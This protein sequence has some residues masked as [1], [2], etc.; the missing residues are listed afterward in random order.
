MQDYLEK[1]VAAIGAVT[2]KV[3]SLSDLELAFILGVF[4][5]GSLWSIASYVA[6]LLEERKRKRLFLHE[7]SLYGNQGSNVTGGREGQ[8]ENDALRQ[9]H[10]SHDSPEKRNPFD[11]HSEHPAGPSNPDHEEDHQDDQSVP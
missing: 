10:S 4:L 8:T 1:A 2:R 5:G 9:W 3:L 6:Y 7:T 11:D